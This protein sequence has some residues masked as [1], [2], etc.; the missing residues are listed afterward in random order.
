M[1]SDEEGA[2]GMGGRSNSALV[3]SSPTSKKALQ[4]KEHGSD[5]AS[6][7]LSNI[8]AIAEEA[9]DSDS[10]DA[11]APADADA[12]AT[13]EQ[14]AKK[15]AAS[16]DE[17]A[18]P[19]AAAAAKEGEKSSSD[20]VAAAAAA[21]AAAASAAAEA[22]V[23]SSVEKPG[24]DDANAEDGA[25]KVSKSP[26]EEGIGGRS[27]SVPTM[28]LPTLEEPLEHEWTIW[29]DKSNRRSRQG[30]AQKDK[31]GED[32]IYEDCIV[33]LGS[34]ATVEVF[35]T[36]WNSLHVQNLKDHCNL[37]V[38]KKGIKP[39]WED[40]MNKRG[41]KW[42][43]RGVPKSNRKQLWTDMIMNLIKGKLKDNSPHTVCGVVLSTR[44]SGD[45]MQL[46]QDG[47]ITLQA[48]VFSYLFSSHCVPH[49]HTHT[50]T[51]RDV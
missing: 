9:T 19:E 49:T 51:A 23:A 42:V 7:S 34:F 47:G 24:D 45:S 2:R 25:E 43:V 37:R 11:A 17:S 1:S 33:E 10:G 21:A 8:K 15:P 36:Y 16:A 20:S 41:G 4:L 35:W 6:L 30:R 5:E 22:A 48:E 12:A 3:C 27:R 28:S 13:A 26:T 32:T 29:F 44:D 38:F 40:K 18:A 39:L 31:R 50:H 46:W 14:D